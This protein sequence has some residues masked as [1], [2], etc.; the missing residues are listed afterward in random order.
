MPR[1]RRGGTGLGQLHPDVDRAR[2]PP[3]PRRSGRVQPGEPA[4]GRLSHLVPHRDAP[5]AGLRRGTARRIFRARRRDQSRPRT[6]AAVAHPPV[7]RGIGPRDRP[8]GT[9]DSA[10]AAIQSGDA[11]GAGRRPRTDAP[12]S[13]RAAARL[14]DRATRGGCARACVGAGVRRASR[15]RAHYEL[16]RVRRSTRLGHQF[17]PDGSR[18]YDGYR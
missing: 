8:F 5:R 15:A 17:P 1:A 11:S 14:A 2:P 9:R 16:A 12:G 4:V 18:Q 7:L 13:S 10:A 3:V 6:I